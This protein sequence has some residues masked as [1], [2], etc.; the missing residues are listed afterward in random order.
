LK[1]FGGI[2]DYDVSSTADRA[3]AFDYDHSGKLDHIVLYRPGSGHLYIIK[4]DNGTFT[5][6]F[7]SYGQGIAEYDL[8]QPTDRVFAFDY[9]HSGKL[10]HLVLYRPG[11]GCFWIL[12]N[13]NGTFKPVY[14]ENDPGRG[15]A[16]YDLKSPAD[17][18]FAFDYDHSGKLDHLVLYRPGARI[19]WI[20]KNSNGSFSTV[21]KSFSGVTYD[22]ALPTDRFFAFDYQRSGKKD[23]LVGYRPGTGHFWIIKNDNGNFTPYQLEGVSARGIG[24]Y[25]VKSLADRAF[26]FDF[27][28]SG[29][30]DHLVLV[31]PGT[32]AVTIL[33]HNITQ[34][35]HFFADKL[36]VHNA[37]CCPGTSG[38]ITPIAANLVSNIPFTPVYQQVDGGSGIGEYDLHS[39]VDRAI[40]F[41]FDHSGKQDH[42]IIYRPGTG[43]FWVMK[44]TNGSFTTIVKSFAGVWMDLRSTADRG[45]A[46]DYEHSGK[47]D[48]LV[49]FRPG[50][51]TIYIFR[52]T[53]GNFQPVFKEGQPVA[54]QGPNGKGIAEYDLSSTADRGF[55]FDYEHSGKLDHIVLYRP[56]A[57]II[58]ILK[59]TNGT[60]STVL[61]SFQGISDYDVSS[62]A[63]RA[64]AFDFDRSGK[65]DH[66]ALYR[67]GS[68]HLYIIKNDNGTFTDV[69]RSYG[70]GIAGYDLMS[71]AD[72][73]VAFDYEH[74][75][76][77]EYL[78]LYRPGAGAFQIL[79]NDK[80]NF[81]PVYQEGAPGR[82]IG[83]FDMKSTVD[84]AVSFDFD[85][86]GK[87][88][89]IL[90]YRPGQGAATIL[91]HN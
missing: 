28:H 4:N 3:F 84:R 86:S 62:P 36:R 52:Q 10:D 71:P 83:A 17:R 6:V 70:Q 53:N 15:I 75:G 21:L 13:D 7:R 51:C 30:S 87:S 67:P 12:K 65:L 81:T 14:R 19:I 89:H 38:P 47:L 48:H 45:F 68:G 42:L 78:A 11:T 5:D 46:F 22:L 34:G 55:A 80:G 54:N 72:R 29:K 40:P 41:D 44:N 77:K 57:R 90:L 85:H 25:D 32:G 63:D 2:S 88:D 8:R 74:S 60:F 35:K 79:K 73:I 69:F 59:N 76:K 31:R 1:S 18:A 43:I 23:H 66:I 9:D 50:T 64:F 91:R 16:E 39:D 20:L 56:G 49:M 26:D 37:D 58:W 33:R 24:G 61:K 27:D 82:G